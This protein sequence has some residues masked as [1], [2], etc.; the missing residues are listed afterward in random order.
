VSE[1][2][3]TELGNFEVEIA[4]ESRKDLNRQIL[5]L[6]QNQFKQESKR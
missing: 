4:V 3:I 2:F 5:V 6:Q 1:P